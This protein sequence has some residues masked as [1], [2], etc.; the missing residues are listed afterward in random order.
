MIMASLA[1]RRGHLGLIARLIGRSPI[2]TVGLLPRAK[3]PALDLPADYEAVD[4]FILQWIAAEAL[5][6][7]RRY[8]PL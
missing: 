3:R 7:R 2:L 5:H 6:R 4:L 8:L 1:R